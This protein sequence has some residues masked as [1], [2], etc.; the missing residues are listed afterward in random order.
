LAARQ[1]GAVR[2]AAALALALALLTGGCTS[3][4]E[5]P[6]PVPLSPTP[7]SPAPVSATPPATPPGGS[8]DRKVLIIAEEN[9]PYDQVIGRAAAPY[10]NELAATYGTATRMTAG[11][12]VGCPSL[13]AY[14]LMTSGSTHGICDD[15]PPAQH[16]LDGPNIFAQVVSAG[17]TWRAYAE[18]AAGNCARDNAGNGVFLVRH[19][20]APYYVSER[21]RCPKF[22]L[23]SGTPA[24]GALRSDVT[25]GTL[26]AFGFVTPNACND[27]H[28]APGC[29]TNLIGRGDRW[30][31]QWVPA[32][33]AGPD[34]Q[35]GRLVIMIVWDEGDASTNH[36][37]L[38][39]IS[40]ATR[41]VSY[42]APIDHCTT[43]R[44]VEDLLHLA[45]LGCAGTAPSL[46]G[47]FHLSA[48]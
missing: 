24:A 13:A 18:D 36:I 29:Q 41:S 1:R 10:V 21:E 19:V 35:A 16:Q 15:A 23:P 30:L 5:R 45:P 2:R 9:R 39:V 27:M 20:P 17:R 34:Y 46:V 32:L 8:A 12:P 6:I 33:L 26:P 38:I 14:V 4:R 40:P 44:T 43:L 22:D 7:H 47:P 42:D 11:Y 48:P 37:P 3:P 25:A 31:R 28:G